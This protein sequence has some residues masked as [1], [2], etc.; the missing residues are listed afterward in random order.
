MVAK[1]SENT[2]LKAVE[3]AKSKGR[4]P[5]KAGCA[6][7]ICLPKSKLPSVLLAHCRQSVLK[8][9]ITNE[10]LTLVG[11]YDVPAQYK[12]FR[13]LYLYDLIAAYPTVHTVVCEVD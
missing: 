4:Q 5:Q 1:K 2:H 10:K 9:S 3:E 11:Y 12:Q 8:Y 13:K 7:R 6:E